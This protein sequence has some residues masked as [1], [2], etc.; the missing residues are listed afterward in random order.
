M[1]T[2]SLLVSAIVAKITVTMGSH[3][4]MFAF[5]VDMFFMLLL[6]TIVSKPV[7]HI[8]FLIW[9]P[10]LIA[11]FMHSGI[12]VTDYLLGLSIV[13]PHYD[14]TMLGLNIVQI[15]ILLAGCDGIRN[16]LSFCRGLYNDILLSLRANAGLQSH[17]ET[18]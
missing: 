17:K 15:L 11:L 12:L 3:Y 5:A 4:Y 7:V 9:I 8:Y 16:L 14:Q 2:F 1:I 6:V 13:H 18:L 10:Y